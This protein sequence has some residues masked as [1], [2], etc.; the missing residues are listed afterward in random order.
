MRKL[1]YRRR[2]RRNDFFH[3]WMAGR[4][5][6][7]RTPDFSR[8]RP[9]VSIIGDFVSDEIR[10]EQIYERDTLEFLRDRV[11]DLTS[12]AQSAAIDVGANIGNHSLFLSD[13]FGQ[14]LAFEPNPLARAL[15]RLNV[16]M[17]G[18]TNVEVRPVGLSDRNGTA[19]LEFDPL[20]LGAAS[21]RELRAMRS[22][23]RR[24]TIDLMIGDEAVDAALKIGFIKIDVE[25]AEEAVLRGLEQT[26]R[27]HAPVVMMEQW[28]EVIDRAGTSPS[29]SF[30]RE[31]GYSMREIQ[32]A[33]LFR[34][35]LG[36]IPSLLLGHIDYS[37][38]PISRLE[39]R[40]YPALIFTPPSYVFPQP[41]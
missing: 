40:E 12:A 36:K 31:L 10:A 29:V 4:A 6:R 25:G 11:L 3:E 33:P 1:H 34:G 13:L 23:A 24:S 41:S 28:P 2:F 19:T 26:L 38:Q 35:Q 5:L 37:L 32:R 9:M 22:I 21:T 30:L 39:N 27:T 14:V 20:N 18:I 17:N 16:E 8:E 15:L 7:R